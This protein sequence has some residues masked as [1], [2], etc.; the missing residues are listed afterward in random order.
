VRARQRR[1]QGAESK[2][3]DDRWCPHEPRRRAPAGPDP[4]I[5]KL[6]QTERPLAAFFGFNRNVS[7]ALRRRRGRQGRSARADRWD[8]LLVA[9]SAGMGASFVLQVRR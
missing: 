4:P 9:E 2:A 5:K 7:P 1:L 3:G 8:Q 6:R